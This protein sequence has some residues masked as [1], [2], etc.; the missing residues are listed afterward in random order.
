[1]SNALNNADLGSIPALTS[2]AAFQAEVA[3]DAIVNLR[4]GS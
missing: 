3:A 4:I 1:M 2:M